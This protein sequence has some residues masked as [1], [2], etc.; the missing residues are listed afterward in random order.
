M[1][2]G[3]AFA[4]ALREHGVETQE[5]ESAP[6]GVPVIVLF[7]G[8]G[9]T[10]PGALADLN[11][12]GQERV[13][14]VNLGVAHLPGEKKWGVLLAGASD[15][16]V[17]GASFEDLADQVCARL[18]RWS[19]VDELTELPFLRE[20]LIGQ[21]T[22]W[23]ALLRELVEAGRYTRASVLLIGET[24]T[25]KELLA[26]SIHEVDGRPS[27][28]QLVIV[29]CTT[30]TQELA[31]SELFGHER[32]AFTGA[33]GERDGACALA[34]G[35]TLFLDE[36]GELPAHLQAQLLR[37]VQEAKYKR[38]GGNTWRPSNF[39]LVSATNRDLSVEVGAGR[40]RSDLYY[41]IAGCVIQ[42]PSLRERRSD[43]P[44]LA[45][46]FLEKECGCPAPEFDD[47]VQDYLAGRDYPGN[48][49]ELRQLVTRIA[50]RHTGRGPI[51]VGDIPESDRPIP[52]WKPDWRNEPLENVVREAL[53]TG[54]SLKD[55]TQAAADS[56]IRLAVDREEGS[57]QRAAQRLGV[58]ARALQLRR[59]HRRPP[60]KDATGAEPGSCATA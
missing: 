37:V 42:A 60:G 49:R 32:G 57:L 31:G 26:R 13:L 21:S 43:I 16:L 44:T 11:P 33:A 41:R 51:T 18:K 50:H 58:T 35:G 34:D 12:T 8:F 55:V 10:L 40:F 14:A 6:P 24:G 22:P 48:V 7:H 2:L 30:I 27:K 38:V 39:R 54:A 29:D 56:A 45:R 23:R 19:E 15:L 5:F 28:G 25:G 53:A 1:K 20:T 17:C 4:G 47:A 36:I 52:A 9:E 46:H 59:A 3:P